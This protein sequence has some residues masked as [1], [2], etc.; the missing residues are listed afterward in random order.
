MIKDMKKRI[1]NQEKIEAQYADIL[2]FFEIDADNA[3]QSA[4]EELLDTITVFTN[5]L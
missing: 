5:K 2:D 4:H 1:Q 3:N